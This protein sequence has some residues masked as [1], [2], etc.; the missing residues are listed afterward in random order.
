MKIDWRLHPT[1]GHG[2]VYWL[3]MKAIVDGQAREKAGRGSSS[4]EGAGAL[5]GSQ[6]PAQDEPW[7]GDGAA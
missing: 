7:S 4:Q 2:E 6:H 1:R 3:T 5:A